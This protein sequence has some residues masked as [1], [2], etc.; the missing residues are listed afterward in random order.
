MWGK[1]FF[2]ALIWLGGT[3]SALAEGGTVSVLRPE[4]RPPRAQVENALVRPPAPVLAMPAPALPEGGTAADLT[5]G[6]PVIVTDLRPPVRPGTI[7]RTRWQ[8]MRGHALWSRAAVSA[9]KGHG[10]PLVD[11]VPRDIEAWCPAYPDKGAAE[12]RAFWVGFLSALAKHES[13]YQPWAVG[14]GGRWYGLLQILPSTAR[15]YK[16]NV[17]TGEALK[18]GPANLS[19]AVRI[20]A[21]TVTRD[22]VIHGYRGKRGQGVTADWG[23]MHSEAKRR[24]MARWLR[25]QTYCTK[26]D[27]VRPKAR[28]T[29]PL[30]ISMA[31]D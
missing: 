8:H 23:P 12:R 22:G 20:M 27:T 21:H 3:L 7:P 30:W 29:D 5:T 16:C 24:D 14:G 10:Q 19:C 4:M 17:G 2:T 26:V 18:S 1:S 13:T 25:R 31:T 15:G 6:A 9:L 11:L 28:P